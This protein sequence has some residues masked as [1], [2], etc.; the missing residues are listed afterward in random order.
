MSNIRSFAR[1]VG[2]VGWLAIAWLPTLKVS[3][4][5]NRFR[6]FNGQ[7][8]IEQ[9]K[10]PMPWTEADVA[11]KI[12][13][14]GKGNGSPIV[15]GN[16]VFLMSADAA[17]AERFALA[18]DL[19][20][21]QERWRK[22]FAGQTHALHAKSSYASCTPCANEH[23]VFF[24]WAAPDSLTVKAFSH[25]GDELWTQ[26]LGRY[27]SAHG[28]GGSPVLIDD[29]LI[30][31]N[32]QDA[33]ELPAGVAPGDSS[34]LALDTASG[35]VVWE[36]PRKSVRTCYGAPSVTAG[37][38]GQKVLIF[39]ETGD[40]L[41]ALDAATGKQL[42]NKQVFSKRSVSCPVIVGD[43]AVCTEGS[44]GGGNTLFAVN[45]TGDHALAYEIKRAAPYVPTPVAQGELLFLW[46][47]TGIVSCVDATRGETFWSERI[48]GN[49]SSSPVIAGDKLL[50]VD[51]QG[52]V[53]ILSAS[54]SFQK[55]GKVELGETTRS[56]PLLAE[57]YLMI[58]TDAHLICVGNPQ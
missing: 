31:S 36:T 9:C 42:W 14:P 51:E 46:G 20:T 34:I 29:K 18:Y 50:G 8:V 28:F 24:A 12:E 44:G 58:R 10:V 38:N 21:G 30:L 39:A 27:V 7:G 26:D 53:T 35:N 43:I 48:G 6:G 17:T 4:D 16:S 22:A 11:W 33:E 19:A 45:L 32:S 57:N 25:S 40:G 2:C 5:W 52:T 3:A 23:A 47:D 41:F 54:R 55:L 13:L 56:T 1:L 15:A 37:A 49:V